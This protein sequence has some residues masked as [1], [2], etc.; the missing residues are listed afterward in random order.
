VNR[1]TGV[2]VLLFLLCFPAWGQAQTIRVNAGG[3]GYRDTKGQLWSPDQGF[4]TGSLSNSA[5]YSTVTGTSDPTLFKSARVGTSSGAELQYQF[6]VVNGLYKV[7]LY[8]A[9]TYFST[10]GKRV[11][12]VQMQG[13]TVISALDILAQAGARHALVK[14]AQVS[15][16]QGRLVI[17]F[18]HRANGNVPVISAV[19]ILPSGSIA[20]SVTTQPASLSIIPAAT[21]TFQVLAT[22]TAPLSYQWQKNGTAISGATSATYTTPPTT[23]ADNGETFRV[24]ISNLVGSSTSSSAT[25][26][27]SA[28]QGLPIITQQPA[29]QTSPVGLAATFSVAAKGAA[30]LGYQWKRNGSVISGATAPSYTISTVTSADNGSTFQAEIRNTIGLVNS[31]QAS[32]TVSSLPTVTINWSDVHQVIDGFGA[33][34]AVTGDGITS[35]QADL[36]WS[37]TNGV[38]LSLLRV[39]L[40]TDG[41]YPDIATMQKAQ[42]RGVRIWGTPWSPPGSMK[43]NGTTTNGGSLLTSEYQA[44]A[45]YLSKYVL[46][47][48][49]SYGFDLYAMSVQNEPNWVANWDSCIWNGQ[50]FHDFLANNLL[51]TFAKNGIKTK[52]MMPEETGWFF[53]R[54]TATLSDPNTAAGVSIIAAHNY[55]GAQASPYPLGQS[56]GKQ[57]W[58]T[59]VSTTD[60]YDGSINNGLFWGQKISD[61]MTIANANAW[62]YWVLLNPGGGDNGALMGPSNQP[63]K[64][65]YVMGNFSK[66]V[67]PGYYRIGTSASPVSGVSISAYKDPV[68]GKFAIVALNHTGSAVKLTFALNGFVA[69]AVTPWVTSA[70]LDLAQQPDIPVGGSAFAATVPAT[71]VTTF[72]GP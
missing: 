45:D 46:T 62:H 67:R 43:S 56:L 29:N 15:V 1:F 34:S 39:Q 5:V 48:K 55:D 16:T 42:D 19:E 58:E 68:T 49:N 3:S 41:T 37:T 28:T 44:Y 61:W 13:A 51:P 10:A 70:S 54:A 24:V 52:I 17:R 35:S 20:P 27:V 63:T 69:N 47:L 14:S 11:F 9:E 64:R 4:N 33:S 60:P 26:S 59:E 71:S 65:L 6:P 32:L 7:N 18:V 23:L 31:A 38:G 53:D 2:V 57:L 30:P 21:A 8:F 22:G 12:D 36:F 40:Q 25:L 72:V 66:F 50:Q